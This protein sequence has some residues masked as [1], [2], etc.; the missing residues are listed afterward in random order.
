VARPE[1][2]RSPLGF[3]RNLFGPGSFAERQRLFIKN[4]TIRWTRGSACCGNP[5]EPGC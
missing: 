1:P 5:G 3:V 4:W 2:G